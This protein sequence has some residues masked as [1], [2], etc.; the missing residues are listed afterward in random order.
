ME[1]RALS[2]LGGIE[3]EGV[4]LSRPQS[5]TESRALAALYDEH[6]LVVFRGQSMTKQQLV[7]AAIPFGGPMIDVPGA[8][9]HAEAPGI[10]IV[11][12]RGA[13][14]TITPRRPRQAGRQSRMA[15]RSGLA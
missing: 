1:V 13:D 7:K 11:S 10:S 14:G 15:Y 6:G 9:L 8:A 2:P 5:P 3:V 12:T 4:D